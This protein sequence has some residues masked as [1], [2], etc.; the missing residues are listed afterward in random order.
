M[1]QIVRKKRRFIENTSIQIASIYF[2]ESDLKQKELFNTDFLELIKK[3]ELRNI[4]I[5]DYF[6]FTDTSIHKWNVYE[7]VSIFFSAK[8]DRTD[9]EIRYSINTEKNERRI[10]FFWDP[11]YDLSSFEDWEEMIGK[12]M[13]EEVVPDLINKLLSL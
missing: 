2:D 1:N 8:Y 7:D 13:Y 6:E 9:I 11:G 5:M 3:T 10:D 4:T 12:K